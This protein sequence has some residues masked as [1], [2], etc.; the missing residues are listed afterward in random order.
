MDRPSTFLAFADQY[1]GENTCIQALVNLRWNEG[2]AC[3]KCGSAKAY[4]LASRPRVF[5]C[6]ACGHQHSI[7]AG[8]IFHKTRTDLRK[9]FLAA[10]LMMHD[11]RG[12]SAMMLSREL[13]IRYETAW[14][15]AHKL[16][17]AL[18]ERTDFRLQ[19]FVEVDE[20]FYGGKGKPANRGRGKD[21]D[22][23][24]VV[25]VVERIPATQKQHRGIRKQ[26]FVAGSVRMAVAL[27]ATAKVLGE[28][29]R[30]NV[31]P[32]SSVVTDGFSSYRN[33]LPDYQHVAAVASGKAAG[34]H[35]PVVHTLFSNM[36]SW[37]I[38]THHG[39]STKHLPRYLREWT[40]RFNRRGK[41][42]RLDVLMLRR[43][44]NKATITYDELMS[45][46][47]TTGA[48]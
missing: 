34:T 44:V 6:A 25:A 32:G 20:T 45:G 35:L 42:A 8:T 24:L 16:R 18:S 13:S 33:Q 5:E 30:S 28:F 29:I 46:M 47:Q 40:Y 7:T 11:K 4:H 14:L 12:V 10:Y 23:S 43:A 1:R 41:I 31:K 22:R 17:H 9:W 21:E 15:M 26:G 39:V 48:A 37:L 2:F 36:K 38:G 27:N 3:D 19:D